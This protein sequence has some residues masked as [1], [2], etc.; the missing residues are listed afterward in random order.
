MMSIAAVLQHILLLLFIF[1]TDVG[2]QSVQIG[3]TG[4]LM[5]SCR[6]YHCYLVTLLKMAKHIHTI[7]LFNA[8]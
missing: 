3:P 7:N 1:E 6:N 5:A 2:G 4:P 8:K